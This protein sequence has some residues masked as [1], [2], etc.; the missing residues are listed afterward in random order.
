MAVPD[1]AQSLPLSFCA[2]RGCQK[3]RS[4][5]Q[6]CL[7]WAMPQFFTFLFFSPPPPGLFRHWYFLGGGGGGGGKKCRLGTHLP[8]SGS[9]YACCVILG[10]WFNLPPSAVPAFSMKGESS[11]QP[12]RRGIN[13]SKAHLYGVPTKGSKV[14]SRFYYLHDNRVFYS[15][16]TYFLPRL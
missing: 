7:P 6:A 12:Q 8:R 1:L 16:I 10:K 5:P 13:A 15:I 14:G 9:Y 3:L 4:L 11:I 2:S